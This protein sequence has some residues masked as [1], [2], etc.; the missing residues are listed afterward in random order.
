HRQK[1]VR[2]KNVVHDH[3]QDQQAQQPAAVLPH[4][5][6]KFFLGGHFLQFLLQLSNTHFVA[7]PVSLAD[8]SALVASTYK[9][10]SGSVPAS[11]SSIHDPSSKLNLA[12][13]VRSIDT[14][15]RPSSVVASTATFFTAFAFC[16]SLRCRF[17]RTG[18][19]SLPTFLKSGRICSPIEAPRAAI[20]SATSRHARMPSFSGTCPRI[21]SP[22][23]SSPPRAILSS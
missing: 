5:R 16:S 22:A 2:P 17:S 15:F 18:Q 13:S 9:R 23:L 10:N 4:Q 7:S 11:R 8:A 20:I 3:H 14:T 1:T 21:V 6:P 12:P 19:N